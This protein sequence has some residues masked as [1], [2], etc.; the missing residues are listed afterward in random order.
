MYDSRINLTT[1]GVLVTLMKAWPGRKAQ[2]QPNE[3]IPLFY[4]VLFYVCSLLHCP[5][6]YTR[7]LS[8][9]KVVQPL[10]FTSYLH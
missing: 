8:G 9:K 6:S 1:H 10:L 7:R 4:G 3:M 5:Q 2:G